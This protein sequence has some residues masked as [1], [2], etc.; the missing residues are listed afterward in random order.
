LGIE[1]LGALD[2]LLKVHS[3]F[4]AYMKEE[5]ELEREGLKRVRLSRSL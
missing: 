3:H 4:E 2:G 1:T 5:L